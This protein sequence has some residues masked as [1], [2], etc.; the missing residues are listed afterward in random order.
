MIL[1]DLIL[2]TKCKALV[3]GSWEWWLAGCWMFDNTAAAQVAVGVVPAMLVGA[4][5][6]MASRQ[7][8]VK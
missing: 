6:Y 1:A 4:L 3:E 7:P 5:L 8:R 2:I